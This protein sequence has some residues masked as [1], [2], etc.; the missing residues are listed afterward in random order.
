MDL[1]HQELEEIKKIL[2][3]KVPGSELISC[4]KN[5]VSVKLIKT[6]YKQLT[7]CLQFPSDYPNEPILIE[8][9]SKVFSPSLVNMITSICDKEA[10]KH[11]GRKQIILILKFLQQFLDDNPLLPCREEWAY[12]KKNI[13]EECDSDKVKQ[14]KGMI[15]V[16][17][18][19]GNYFLKIQATIPN[20]YPEE[21]VKLSIEDHN[22]PGPMVYYFISQAKEYARQATEPPLKKNPKAPAF[23]AEPHLKKTM[24]F[25]I[26]KCCKRFPQECCPMCGKQS[27]PENPADI[28]KDGKDDKYIERVYC[29]HLYH[30]GCMDAYMK[31]PPFEN[32]KMC[33]T[34]GLRIYHDKWNISP[35]L[36]EDRWAHGEARQRELEEVVDFLS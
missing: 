8:V 27:L 31:T 10:K 23:K 18:T 36:A 7:A 21:P 16:K 5:L 25:L 20:N 22:F 24:E 2:Q 32:G 1:I 3:I 12:I 28:I 30:H 9:K 35:R 34:C 29:G 4:H 17:A 26:K 19:R 13:L 6:K 11:I 33:P 14:K 15:Q